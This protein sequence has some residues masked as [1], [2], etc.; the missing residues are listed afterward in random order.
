MTLSE[1]KN[2]IKEI[3]D[4]TN[5]YQLSI[6]G[7][8]RRLLAMGDD[9]NSSATSVVSDITAKE[10]VQSSTDYAIQ[11]CDAIN[12]SLD[13]TRSTLSKLGSDAT[14][15]IRELV[16]SYNNSLD[17][18]STEERLSYVEVSLSSIDGS[19]S[20]AVGST[21]T[22]RLGNNRRNNNN[23]YS[24]PPTDPNTQAPEEFD[25]D[26]YLGLL[27]TTGINS[28]DISNWDEEIKKFLEENELDKY[29][30]KME[31][32]GDVIKLTLSNDKEVEIKD[33]TNK[34][35]LLEKIDEILKE[36]GLKPEVAP[37]E[38]TPNEE[39]NN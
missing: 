21:G 38:E 17:P 18:E 12:N 9:I 27:S 8:Q 26:Y 24:D 37:G 36:E 22:N 16:D 32:E 14:K 4:S 31:L 6:N 19:V 35:E 34:E 20:C 10:V 5:D 33:V 2:S 15:R 28:A 29:I 25:I 39:N 23:N 13:I 7:I 3:V 1:T 11:I 30:N